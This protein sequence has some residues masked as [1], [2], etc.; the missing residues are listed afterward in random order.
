MSTTKPAPLVVPEDWPNAT[1]FFS[2]LR[3]RADLGDEEWR[4]VVDWLL[5]TD[6]DERN[7]LAGE[8][9]AGLIHEAAPIELRRLVLDAVPQ[10]PWALRWQKI[11]QGLPAGRDDRE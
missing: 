2:Q 10:T 8:A 11:V 7:Y 9:A 6:F 4:A 3:H 5:S 1:L